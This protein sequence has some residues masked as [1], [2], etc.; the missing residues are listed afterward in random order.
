MQSIQL[1]KLVKLVNLVNHSKGPSHQPLLSAFLSTFLRGGLWA[2]IWVIVTASGLCAI[3]TWAL[4]RGWPPGTAFHARDVATAWGQGLRFDL[5]VSASLVWLLWPIWLIGFVKPHQRGLRPVLQSLWIGLPLMLWLLSFINVYYLDF[6][7]HPIDSLIFGLFED[8]TRAIL[9]SIWQDF[10]VIS[11]LCSLGM[12]AWSGLWMGHALEKRVLRGQAYLSGTWSSLFLLVLFL[13]LLF[14]AKG[15]LRG[16]PLHLQNLTVTTN[17][18]LNE[19][20]ANGPIALNFAWDER[21]AAHDFEDVF[22]G[23]RARGYATPLQAAKTLGWP[24][25]NEAAVRAHLWASVSSPFPAKRR[26]VIFVLMESWGAEPL[27]AH[28]AGFDTLGRLADELPHACGFHHVDAANN[29]THPTLEGLLFSTPLTPLTPL[30][31]SRGMRGDAELPWATARIFQRAGFR[32]LFVTSTRSGWRHLDRVLPA[33]GFDEVIDANWLKKQHPEAELGMWGVWDHYAFDYVQQRLATQAAEEAKNPQTRPLF[34]FVLTATNHTP[35]DLPSDYRLAPQNPTLWPGEKGG[36]F[37]PSLQAYR[38]S[39]DA[40]GHFVHTLRTGP[41]GPHTLI[42]A[43]GDH[44]LRSLGNYTQPQRQPWRNRVP[45]AFWGLGMFNPESSG[46][47]NCGPQTDWPASHLDV[48]PTLYALLGI[49]EPFLQTGR[50][51]FAST[52]TSTPTAR[53]SVNFEGQAQNPQGIWQLGQP[54]TWICINSLTS[55][56]ASNCA[57]PAQTDAQER[58][59]LGLIDW[60]IR[61]A[62]HALQQK[63]K[64]KNLRS[65]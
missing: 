25:Q 10:P 40:L 36:D 31:P 29:G 21:R 60:Y 53:T 59:R 7:K 64:A 8:D 17:P 54:S 55:S 63:Q 6:Y 37:V 44:N 56:P 65:H 28:Q 46:H 16:L 43:T 5:K 35:Y 1:V 51:L 27:Y 39:A 33:Q 41:A 61:D 9:G 38:Y 2:W 13:L 14:T 48:F 18:F 45:L 24:V 3:R 30:P 15:T 12:M 57:F 47:L 4:W 32:T 11:V 58:A 42:A 23:L 50:N 26:N 22:S 52:P 20:V 19:H 62:V 34:V 49:Q